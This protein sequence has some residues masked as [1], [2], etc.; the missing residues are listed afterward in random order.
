MCT[1]KFISFLSLKKKDSSQKQHPTK[2]LPPRFIMRGYT[3]FSND[4][5]Y[6]LPLSHKPRDDERT[7]C[8]S[9]WSGLH[10][11]WSYLVGVFQGPPKPEHQPQYRDEKEKKYMHVP[12]HAASS[13]LSSTTTA[14]MVGPHPCSACEVGS[15]EEASKH[16]QT[17]PDYSVPEESLI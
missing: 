1:K 13:Y 12:T 4:G 16:H 6:D 17:H 2:R 9:C 10:I 15:C 8:S 11:F 7:A 14:A 5:K 3:L